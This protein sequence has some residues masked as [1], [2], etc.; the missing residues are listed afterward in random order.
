MNG[1]MSTL[2]VSPPP[3]VGSV[4]SYSGSV[5]GVRAPSV[6]P[7]TAAVVVS[8]APVEST[9]VN[10]PVSAGPPAG[11]SGELDASVT[12]LTKAPAG[13]PVPVTERPA[14]VATIESSRIVDTPDAAVAPLSVRA[15]GTWLPPPRRQVPAGCDG[16]VCATHAS[17]RSTNALSP[18][19]G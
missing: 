13:M 15:P 7:L 6:T 10:R 17:G 18:G 2:P 14:S 9:L 5:A 11:M 1:L 16:A 4:A 8:T 3:F 19:P 12:W